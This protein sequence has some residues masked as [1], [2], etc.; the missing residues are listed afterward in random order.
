MHSR[1]DFWRIKQLF[2]IGRRLCHWNTWWT[3]HKLSTRILWS[4]TGSLSL[5]SCRMQFNWQ[6]RR[7][8]LMQLR[9]HFGQLDKRMHT[10]PRPSHSRLRQQ[11][12]LPDP[13]RERP[14][15][16]MPTILQPGQRHMRTLR[17]EPPLSDLPPQQNLHPMLL[18]LQVLPRQQQRLL[19]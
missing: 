9:L 12:Q 5:G 1:M 6:Q 8:Y 3:L 13:G 10:K 2:P 7:L 18:P 16:I 4:S 14:M 17:R 19:S 15:H 11:P